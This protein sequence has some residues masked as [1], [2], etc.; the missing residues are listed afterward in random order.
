MTINKYSSSK[1]AELTAGARAA[2]F[3]PRA[4]AILNSPHAQGRKKLATHLA[5]STT[6]SVEQAC[7]ALEAAPKEA[8]YQTGKAKQGS[9]AQQIASNW[10]KATGG[11][12]GR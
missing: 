6:L 10:V 2:A 4:Q 5:T 3:T 12:H 9:R 7:A 1:T 11:S 8:A